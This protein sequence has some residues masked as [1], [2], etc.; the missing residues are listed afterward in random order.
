VI[1]K[2]SKMALVAVVAFATPGSAAAQRT[3][4]ASTYHA[5]ERFTP[6]ERLPYRLSARSTSFKVLMA[7]PAAWAVVLK[8]VPILAIFVKTPSAQ[9][10]L[11]NFSLQNALEIGVTTQVAM[12]RVDR[13]F[14]AME[15]VR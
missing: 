11:A 4:E 14:Q 5:A 3:I 8:E 13:R 6:P 7:H 1:L 9:P 2:N 15:M 12:D 10:F